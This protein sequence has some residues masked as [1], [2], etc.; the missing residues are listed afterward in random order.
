VKDLVSGFLFGAA[1][2]LIS[3]ALICPVPHALQPDVPKPVVFAVDRSNKVGDVAY[4]SGWFSGGWYK[5]TAVSS[6]R[7]DITGL[8]HYVEAVP[9]SSP[10]EKPAP[11][12]DCPCE[13]CKKPAKPNPPVK[14]TEEKPVSAPSAVPIY[15]FVP[16]I[17]Y[18]PP[19][20][21]VR[22]LAHSY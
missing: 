19:I 11:K 22:V 2:I 7:A 5:I 15:T 14:A 18:N 6:N 1:C 16:V 12:C 4:Y 9:V 10:S 21:R 17:R 13:K 8:T 3:V 20:V